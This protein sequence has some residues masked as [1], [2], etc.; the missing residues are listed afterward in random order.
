MILEQKPIEYGIDRNIWTG[1]ILSNVI[2]YRWNIELK[3]ARIY[4]IL[5]EFNLSYQKAH[6]DYANADKEQQKQFVSTLK[7]NWSA[8]K[9][10][11]K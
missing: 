5:A 1:E 3:S 2:K 4:E 10:R 9:R 7:K 6:R 8:E 11:I